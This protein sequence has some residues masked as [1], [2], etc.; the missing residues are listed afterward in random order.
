MSELK[1]YIV[2]LK[3]HKDLDGFYEDMETP[4]GN[5]TIP[6]RIA[7]CCNRREISRNTHYMLTEDEA[8]LVKKDPRV[9][10]VSL[11]PK[12]LPIGITS[13]W[14]Q[15]SAF[16]KS[17]TIDTNDKNW[18]LYRVVN[19]HFSN[20]GTN[21]TFT[22][23]VGDVTTT[24]SGKN[25]DVV[26][27]DSHIN[28]NHP[29]FA[30]N[31][32]GTGG[33]RV[34]QF[35]WFSYSSALGFT[36]QN[37]YEYT[38]KTTE[39]GTH[40]A[41]TVAGNT[42]G[43]ARDANI[44]NIEFASSGV[45]GTPTNWELYLFDYLR[46]F[47]KNKSIN[48][49]TGR[50]NPTITNHSWGYYS[51]GDINNNNSQSLSRIQSVTY[52][53]T[54]TSLS[55]LT[56]AQKRTELESR[57]FAVPYSTYFYQVPYFYSALNAD[58]EDA[59]ADGVIVVAAAMNSTW[60]LPSYSSQ[61]INNSYEYTYTNNVTYTYY[62]NYGG[63]PAAA[64]GCIRVA[65]I[66]SKNEEYKALFTNYGERI[67]VWAPGTNIV[68]SVYSTAAA[69][70]YGITLANDPRNSSYKLGSISGTS[71]ASPQV[72]GVLACIA[73][74]EPDMKQLDAEQYLLETSTPTVGSQGSPSQS[75]YEGLGESPNL[76]LNYKLK[77]QLEGS[78]QGTLFK[79]RRSNTRGV[80]Y[81]RT[82]VKITKTF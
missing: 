16:E 78:L 45:T 42:Q 10:D 11:T 64:E 48:P 39:H 82:N 3:D 27:V 81:P 12:D 59:I 19:G 40:V 80:K 43:W 70:E 22:Q 7:D 29:E 46:Y 49:V 71:M 68:S 60:N 32:D 14:N 53:G 9:L 28:P 50:R 73:E 72:C 30:V 37:T 33:S 20:W 58:V 25:V 6:N 63:S 35:N 24:S 1:E 51:I 31:P 52:R 23:I 79:N 54:K 41:G 21:S 57:G 69:T 77:R 2:T 34:N 8:E 47:H 75:P 17:S 13:G 62:P 56:V 74:Q 38:V 55:G 5:L 26:I 44:Y 76:Y 66:G 4:G 18:G 61:D 67:T 15:F 65:A 36:T